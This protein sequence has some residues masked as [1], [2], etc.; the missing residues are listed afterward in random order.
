MFSY[1]KYIKVVNIGIEENVFKLQD[2]T[3]SSRTT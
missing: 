3:G 1:F 2:T